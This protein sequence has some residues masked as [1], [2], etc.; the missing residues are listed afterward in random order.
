MK[1]RKCSSSIRCQKFGRTPRG[2]QRY[3]CHVCRRTFSEPR[4]SVGNMYLPLERARNATN[5]LVEGNSIRSTARLSGVSIKTVSTMLT[6]IGQGCTNLLRARVRNVD[7]SHLEIDEVW[8]FVG[9]KQKRVKASDTSDVGDAYCFIALDRKTKLVVAWHLGKRDAINTAHFIY[10]VR[11][12]VSAKRF[13]ISSDGWEAY[14]YAIEAGLSDRAS[15]GRIVKVT[16]PGRVEAVI[17]NP[18][19][20]EIETTYIE[21]FNGTLRQW[22]KRYTRKTYAFSKKWEMLEAM[23]ALSFAHYN[24]CRVHR[25]LKST[26]AMAAG[27]TNHAWSVGELLE[28]ACL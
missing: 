21:R 7:I 18:N 3:R 4:Q 1:C 14:E 15:Y 20:S 2:S 9:K 17:G 13:Q 5:L 27:L 26:P 23:L 8:T 24:F 19:V 16:N 12:A 6:Q 11:Q 28:E 10:R 25:T 22:S